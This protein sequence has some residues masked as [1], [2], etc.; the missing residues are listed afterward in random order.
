[1]KFK[2]RMNVNTYLIEVPYW[3]VGRTS[4]RCVAGKKDLHEHGILHGDITQSNVLVQN[5]IHLRIHYNQDNQ[6]TTYYL[7]LKHSNEHVIV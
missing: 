1:M 3:N 6:M 5:M 4:N 2:L 7:I